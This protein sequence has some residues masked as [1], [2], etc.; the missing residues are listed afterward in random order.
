MRRNAYEEPA[1]VATG[2]G[3]VPEASY[4]PS[5]Y[6]D[7]HYQSYYDTFKKRTLKRV[8]LEVFFKNKFEF[9]RVDLSSR[10]ASRRRIGTRQSGT[11]TS[12]TS[13]ADHT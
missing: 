10:V 11:N 2:H 3:L 12:G 7:D 13:T 5:N 1:Y 9:V 8:I 6:P 4:Q